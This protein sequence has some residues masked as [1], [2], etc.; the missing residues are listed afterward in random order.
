METKHLVEEHGEHEHPSEGVYIRIALILAVLTGIEVGLYYTDF[1]EKLT[2]GMLL[3]LAGGKFVLV[4]AYFMHLKF[5]S[6]L[7][8]R[9]FASGFVLAVL[10]YVAYLMTLGIFI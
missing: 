3:A 10:V 7:L 6:R 9:L 1:G 2:N 5:D 8:R 4:V